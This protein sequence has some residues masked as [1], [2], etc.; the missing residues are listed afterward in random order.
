[1]TAPALGDWLNFSVHVRVYNLKDLYAHVNVVIAIN[2]YGGIGGDFANK[3][4]EQVMP[5]L[6]L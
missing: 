5:A 2:M 3:I 1:M 4:S 6:Y